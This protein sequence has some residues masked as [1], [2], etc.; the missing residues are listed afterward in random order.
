MIHAWP[1]A[2]SEHLLGTPH[3]AIEH[4]GNEQGRVAGAGRA[5]HHLHRRVAGRQRVVACHGDA[6]LRAV[7]RVV[8][9]EREVDRLVILRGPQLRVRHRRAGVERPVLRPVG[10]RDLPLVVARRLVGHDRRAVDAVAR[11]AVA[12]QPVVV[13]PVAVVGTPRCGAARVEVATRVVRHWLDLNRQDGA[14]LP[15]RAIELEA[16]LRTRDG[17][18]RRE[19]ADIGADVVHVVQDTEHAH[20]PVALRGEPERVRPRRGQRHLGVHHGAI[21]RERHARAGPATELRV[22]AEQL[23]HG[24]GRRVVVGR[25]ADVRLPRPVRVRV[26]AEVDDVTGAARPHARVLV[27]TV[28]VVRPVLAPV[29]VRDLEAVDT[30]RLVGRDVARVHAIT[31]GAVAVQPVIVELV[32]RVEVPRG[33]GAG[34][35]VTARVVRARGMSACGG[36]QQEQ[37]QRGNDRCGTHGGLRGVTGR[38][39]RSSATRCRALPGRSS[40]MRRRRRRR[41]PSHCGCSRPAR[42]PARRAR[43]SRPFGR[44]ERHVGAVH[45]AARRAQAVRVVRRDLH[46]RQEDAVRVQLQARDADIRA[47][48]RSVRGRR[49]RVRGALDLEH[50]LAG[51]VAHRGHRLAAEVGLPGHGGQ[52][53]ARQLDVGATREVGDDRDAREHVVREVPH[54]DG[55]V[56]AAAIRTVVGIAG[57]RAFDVE[58]PRGASRPDDRRLVEIGRVGERGGRGEDEQ[59]RDQDGTGGAQHGEPPLVRPGGWA[60]AVLARYEMSAGPRRKDNAS[61]GRPANDSAVC[62]ESLRAE[63]RGLLG[64]R[65]EPCLAAHRRR[66]G[67]VGAVH[68]TAVVVV[69]ARARLG[70][71]G[72]L[73]AL[74]RHERHVGTVHRTTRRT[75][76]VHV[77]RRDLQR[78]QRDAVGE[79]LRARDVG[80]RA[81]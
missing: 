30:R 8:R 32:A 24:A 34:V 53:V 75:E 2:V 51:R 40:T 76:P 64:P 62:A 17:G 46:L 7:L 20:V 81:G 15:G 6:R 77:V 50:D 65:A 78:P 43:S 73:R 66:R 27:R 68:R 31:G 60:M 79:H 4:R 54:R 5:L 25:N 9:V 42:A 14:R 28:H 58:V 19:R 18:R 41:S 56:A 23:E 72:D 52:L 21:D 33:R 59:Q 12:V 45:R 3:G 44:Y 47:G 10:S 29:G 16:D 39:A 57:R 13:E 48:R 38:T 80:V 22:A 26:E 49:R 67:D 71:E 63:R 1:P 61:A 55:H 69:V 35:V 11:R 74:G 37:R 36:E 70:T